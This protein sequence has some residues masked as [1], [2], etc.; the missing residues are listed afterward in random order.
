MSLPADEQRQ[1][2]EIEQALCRDDPRFVRLMRATDPRVQYERKLKY[3]L[4]GVVIGAGLLAA[5]AVTHRVYLGTAGVC[6]CCCP[7]CGRW[8]AGGGKRPWPSPGPS[9]PMR[10]SARPSPPASQHTTAPITVR[11]FAERRATSRRTRQVARMFA[12][13]PGLNPCCCR[14][15][16]GPRRSLEIA[17]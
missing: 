7:W 12:A 14:D 8:S 9:C 4:L 16:R 11:R 15:R 2:Q 5:R 13:P 17:P 6:S 1:L 3:A 10:S